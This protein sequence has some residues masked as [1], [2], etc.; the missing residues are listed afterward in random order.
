MCEFSSLILKTS[1]F[2]KLGYLIHRSF[3]Q[4][5]KERRDFDAAANHYSVLLPPVLQV[6][7]LKRS[8]L[9]K[10]KKKCVENFLQMNVLASEE[11]QKTMDNVG[12]SRAGYSN[13]YKSLQGTLKQ[14]KLKGSLFPQPVRVREARIKINEQIMKMLGQPFHIQNI[15]QGNKSQLKFDQY[16]NIFFNLQTL[17]KCMIKFYNLSHEE[18]KGVA[19]F[20][21]KLDESEI[22][23]NKKLERVSIT[24]MN[25]A[26]DQKP[27]EDLDNEGEK[28]KCFSVQSELNIWWLGAFEVDTEDFNILNWVFHQTTIPQVIK[29]QQ[30]GAALDIENF[31]KYKVEWHMAGDL[32]TLKCMYNV[33]KGASSKTPCLYC[34][35][36]AKDCN[37]T[38]WNKAPNRHTKDSQFQGVL[39]IPLSNV[40]ICTLHALCRI[41]EKLVH[42]YIG[43]AFK[44]TPIAA[45]DGAV[46]RIEE[47]LSEIGLH[48]GNVKIETDQKKSRTGNNV[49]RKP[50]V[51]GVK[52]RRFL[53]F[54]GEVGKIN[55]ERGESNIKWNMW[56]LLHNA[57]KDHGD[58]G[59]AR[60]RKAR[61]W[62]ALDSVFL[63]CDKRYWSPKDETAFRKELNN[64]IK[65]MK[66]AWTSESI[67]HYMV[68]I[69]VT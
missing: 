52:A 38:N 51:G 68:I 48:G 62:E 63:Y 34:M 39:D 58:D 55:R 15:Y 65:A 20:V 22:L 25:R 54:H 17:Q 4:P 35:Q 47:A 53:G 43:F 60:N 50:S 7:F 21:I 10:A 28:E 36:Q 64:F 13:L 14:N 6:I 37:S 31:G 27:H 42:L 32:K 30:A 19:K 66:E 44:L 11:V 5:H 49:P 61:V 59:N 8:G 40:H 3:L 46:K 23:K 16:N 24:L 67:T 45:R 1:C 9:Q 57:V 29:S 56:K 26:L 18:A 41:V 33:S 69:T 12:I 2:L